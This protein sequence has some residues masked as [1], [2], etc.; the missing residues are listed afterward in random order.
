MF[1]SQKKKQI[2]DVSFAITCQKK[3]QISDVLKLKIGDVCATGEVE[4][5]NASC[6]ACGSIDIPAAL[7]ASSSTLSVNGALAFDEAEP[8][9]RPHAVS[10]LNHDNSFGVANFELESFDSRMF[11]MLLSQ[12]VELTRLF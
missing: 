12:N 2:S 11:E 7:T 6:K 1:H 9:P 4:D 5:C 8:R 3:K 10:N